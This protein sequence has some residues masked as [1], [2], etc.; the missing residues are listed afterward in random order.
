MNNVYLLGPH[1]EF[2]LNLD[3][4]QLITVAR[5]WERYLKQTGIKYEETGRHFDN[6]PLS[7]SYH[8]HFNLLTYTD[9]IIIKLYN[10]LREVV[11]R[12]LPSSENYMMKSWFNI[13]KPGE[14]IDYHPHMTQEYDALYGHIGVMNTNNTVTTW[15]DNNTN[16]TVDW[17]NMDGKGTF[18]KP[19]NTWHRCW[20]QELE[21]ITI[22]FDVMNVKPLT[23]RANYWVPL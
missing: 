22:G 21:R 2:D 20:P 18:A 8:D 1:Y 17:V 15:R 5:K 23:E 10:R 13:Y 14:Y 3:L 19:N 7:T 12:I 11:L 9:P 16:E 6:G 4:D